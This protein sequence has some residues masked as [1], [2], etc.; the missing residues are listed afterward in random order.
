MENWL[1]SYTKFV[2]KTRVQ[3]LQYLKRHPIGSRINHNSYKGGA[4]LEFHANRLS[5]LKVV[6]IYIGVGYAPWSTLETF[7]NVKAG[8]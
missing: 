6:G 7:Y 5:C 1:R 4:P 2:P 8:V 3:V